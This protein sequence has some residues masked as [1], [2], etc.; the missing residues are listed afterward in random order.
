MISSTDSGFSGVNLTPMMRWSRWNS[1]SRPRTWFWRY[2]NLSS[3]RWSASR[4][5]LSRRYVAIL[6]AS[7]FASSL[8]VRSAMCGP[9]A[10]SC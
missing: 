2:P 5:A 4:F 9:K 3:R 10:G 1:I 7:T 8:S 6:C